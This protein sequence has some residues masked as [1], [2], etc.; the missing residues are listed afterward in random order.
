M[1]MLKVLSNI[2]KTWLLSAR[3]SATPVF[4]LCVALQL[5]PIHFN[6]AKLKY[7]TKLMDRGGAA[8]GRN[9]PC[10]SNPEQSL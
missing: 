1:S 7:Q 10:P 8:Y 4:R 3:N 9:Q 2:R 5:N 6:G